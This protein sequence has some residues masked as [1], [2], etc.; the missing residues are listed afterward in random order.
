MQREDHY[1]IWRGLR[2]GSFH[3]GSAMGD[4]LVTS[5][6]NRILI[7]NFGIPATP[8]SLLIALRYLISPL[9]LWAGHL[10]DNKRILGFRRTPIIWLGRAM[11]IASLP[12]LGLSVMRLGGDTTD[13]LSWLF[14]VLSAIIYGV[15]TL[16]SGGPFLALVRD[17]APEARQGSAIATVETMLI[18][19]YAV[20]G[21]GFSVWMP[22]YDQQT[23]WQM[24]I[25]T[26]VVGGIFWLF[27]TL[28]V[29]KRVV[30]E[31]AAPRQA[32]DSL[33]AV[34]SEIWSD[35]RT[36]RFFVFLALTMFSAWAKD[37]ILEPFGADVFDL[38]MGATTR[39]NSYWQTAT[40][41]T[42]IAGGIAWR[43]RPP[44]QQGRIS[45]IGLL[46]MAL[47]MATLA[48]ASLI[49]MGALVVPGLLVF[50]GGFG[51]YT[52]G[53]LSL[54]AV[55]SP[56]RHSG[57]YLGLWSI[58]ILVFKGLGT[59]TGGALRDLFLL[60]L[61]MEPGMAYGIV[62][63]CQAIG[64]ALAVLTLSH[65]DILGFARDSGR[66]VDRLEAQVAVA[67]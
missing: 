25:A 59:F 60:R 47:G 2:L 66:H 46:V 1:S 5:I 3:I 10:T 45:S 17:S 65:I 27:A 31:A 38:S 57:A 33:R 40:V 49:G 9:S 15:A 58:S 13:T 55:M 8:V 51:V 53:G 56:D 64:L 48:G 6:W 20:A 52:F 32:A 39:F 23:F 36:R 14:A 62:F 42:L 22:A 29:E 50:G 19:F 61:G 67:D 28:G 24:I 11:M 12:F 54:M 37:A 21:I 30:G 26:M 35:H 18:I 7:T 4:I 44:E 63:V 41:V 16:I 34:L 43:K